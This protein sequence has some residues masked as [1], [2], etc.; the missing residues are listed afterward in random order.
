MALYILA[1]IIFLTLASLV[2][3]RTP[4]ADSESPRAARKKGGGGYVS[5]RPGGPLSAAASSSKG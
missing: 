2:V 4:D 1:G 3:T 5:R